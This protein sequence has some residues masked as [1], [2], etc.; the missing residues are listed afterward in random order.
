M[1]DTTPRLRTRSLLQSIAVLTLAIASS[2]PAASAPAPS[3]DI[4]S[5]NMSLVANLHGVGG[6]DIAFWG[7]F[8]AVAH[9]PI[10][11]D[12]DNDG[13]VLVDISRP[14]RPRVVSSFRCVESSH[15]IAIW[16]DL[17]FLGANADLAGPECDA[18]RL[19]EAPDQ[20]A[21]GRW[22]G[23]RI[24]SISDPANPRLIASV[25]TNSGA[26]DVPAGPHTFTMLPDLKHRAADGSRDPRLI[27]Y[28]S[29]GGSYLKFEEIVEVPLQRPAQAAVVAQMPTTCHD[30]T[31]FQPRRLGV[32]AGAVS[33]RTDLWDL[34]DPL[35]PTRIGE[36][37]NPSITHHHG[38]A[39]SSDGNTLALTDESALMFGVLLGIHRCPA[40]GAS[41]EAAMWFYDVTEPTRPV[42]KSYFQLPQ[43]PG[44]GRHCGAH[45]Q[46]VVPLADDRDI[47]V[48]AWYTGG[49]TVI[50]FTDPSDPEQLAYYIAEPL[51]EDRFSNPWASYWYNGYV[52][53]SNTNL[54][55][56]G[57]GSKRGLD[58]FSVKHPALEDALPADSFNFGTQ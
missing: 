3:G 43:T 10:D 6:G 52:Y 26:F 4:R 34:K 11:G 45:Q 56:Y 54:P 18:K 39:F 1:R 40:G 27:L 5:T 30:F 35:D 29:G 2:G 57:L 47:L 33:G 36:I 20:A 22:G 53:A 21:T 38:S 50:D 48:A 12:P 42:L 24:V 13:F 17:V 58:V 32:C 9:G 51:S 25:K 49:S 23:L 14:S 44:S 8:A 19:P 28:M 46:N 41:N 16:R 31:V 7:D 15:D 55:S 37:V